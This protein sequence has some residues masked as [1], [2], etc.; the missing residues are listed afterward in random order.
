MDANGIE[1]YKYEY[2]AGDAYGWSN[3]HAQGNELYGIII[4]LFIDNKLTIQ[5]CSSSNL[6]K[7]CTDTIPAPLQYTDPHTE[8][9]SGRY[10]Y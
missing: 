1:F 4:S 6:S 2:K 7:E 5:M 3:K 8:R 9:H 10:S